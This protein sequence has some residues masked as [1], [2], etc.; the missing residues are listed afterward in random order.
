MKKIASVDF[1]IHVLTKYPKRSEY[2]RQSPPKGIRTN[3]FFI[4]DFLETS[5]FDINADDNGGAYVKSCNTNNFYYCDNDQAN[6]VREDISGKSYYKERSSRNSY[7]KVYTTFHKIVKLTRAYTKAKSFPLTKLS[8]KYQIG[9]VA[10]LVFLLRFSTKLQ[11]KMTKFHI[12][13]MPYKVLNHIF[14]RSKMFWKTLDKNGLHA[15]T[16][17]D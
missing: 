14:G 10:F 6:I 16:V 13:E 7:K 8:S 15:K 5:I 4:T 2:F 9:Q 17:C 3:F 11:Q 1:L 12:T